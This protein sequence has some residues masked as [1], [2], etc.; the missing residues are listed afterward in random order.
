MLEGYR[1]TLAALRRVWKLIYLFAD[2][3]RFQQEDPPHDAIWSQ[4]LPRQQRPRCRPSPYAQQ[5]LRR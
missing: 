3:F 2:W 5:D 4:G 1:T